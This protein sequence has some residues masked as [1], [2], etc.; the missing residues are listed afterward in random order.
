MKFCLLLFFVIPITI[1]AQSKPID[2][3]SVR[4]Y[5]RGKFYLKQ[6]SIIIDGTKYTFEDVPNGKY[7]AYKKVPYIYSA[8][9]IEVQ[10]IRKRFLQYDEWIKKLMIPIDHVGD[11]R[12]DSGTATINVSTKRKH[13]QLVIESTIK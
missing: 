8:N 12:I 1:C 10:I 9:W 4:V 3:V 13:H 7:S 2:S 6:Y 5:N 11:K